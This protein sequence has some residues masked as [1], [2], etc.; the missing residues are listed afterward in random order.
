MLISCPTPG[1]DGNANYAAPGRGHAQGC[2]YPW[3]DP[4][5]FKIH[6]N[7]VHEPDRPFTYEAGVDEPVHPDFSIVMRMEEV[8]ISDCNYGCKIYADTRSRLRVL[9]HSRA[10]GCTVT[11][12]GVIAR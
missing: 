1:C 12:E 9:A 5:Q 6:S 11:R 8:A 2:K 4:D 3:V 7:F 10:Y